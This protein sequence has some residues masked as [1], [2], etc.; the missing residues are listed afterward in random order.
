M[1]GALIAG[2]L[3]GLSVAV[4]SAGAALLVME[5]AKRS[6][7][8]VASA[9]GA[10]IATGDAVWATVVVAAGAALHRLM[11]PWA[12]VLQWTGVMV[13]LMILVLAVRELIGFDPAAVSRL[14]VSPGRAYGTF[15]GFT[16][17]DTVTAVFFLSLMLGVAPSYGAHEAVAFVGG[18]LLASLSWQWNAALVGRRRGA[19]TARTRRRALLI[20]AVLLATFVGYLAFGLYRP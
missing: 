16:L 4:L 13:I 14:P 10:G 19:F 8:S 3:V 17:I 20:D 6:G 1:A 15:L 2:L 7:L 9:A 11:A 5:T 12:G 18:V